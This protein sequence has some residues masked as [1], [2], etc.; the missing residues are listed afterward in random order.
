MSK[1]RELG[2]IIQIS[3]GKGIY[4]GETSYKDEL[5]MPNIGIVLT[6]FSVFI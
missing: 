5:F 4:L 3:S 6:V 1:F 2:L